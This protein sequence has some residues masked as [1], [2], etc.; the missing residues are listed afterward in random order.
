MDSLAL[1]SLFSGPGLLKSET[2]NIFHEHWGGGDIFTNT[3]E[4]DKHFH[5]KGGRTFYVGGGVG[6]DNVVK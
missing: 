2:A 3:G 1:D 5:I 4:G 6:F